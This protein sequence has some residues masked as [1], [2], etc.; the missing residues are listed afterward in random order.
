MVDF[1]DCSCILLQ[2]SSP[3]RSLDFYGISFKI[4]RTVACESCGKT[5]RKGHLLH[6]HKRLVHLTSS[7]AKK[8]R[9]LRKRDSIVKNFENF[10]EETNM[11]PLANLIENLE[12]LE[13]S[14]CNFFQ[15]LLVND[16][17]TKMKKMPSI[18][19]VEGIKSHLKNMILDISDLKF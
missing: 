19:T 15:S 3:L 18:N 10:L 11:E 5:F 17:T 4:P 6:K 7:E 14:L 8:A 12:D 1:C 9:T 2:V 16:V 13:T